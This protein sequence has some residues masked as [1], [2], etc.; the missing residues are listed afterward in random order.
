MKTH[1]RKVLEIKGG[2]T[3]TFLIVCEEP[4]KESIVC[5]GM[6]EWAAGWLIEQIQGKPYGLRIPSRD[7]E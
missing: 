2:G 5:G 6:Y 3:P 4:D 7:E 1:Y